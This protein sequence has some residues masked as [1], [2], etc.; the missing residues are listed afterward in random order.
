MFDLDEDD[1]ISLNDLIDFYRLIYIDNYK[2]KIQQNQLK[3]SNLL[4]NENIIQKMAKEMIQNFDVDG[5]KALNYE[6]FK[7]VLLE[8]LYFAKKITKIQ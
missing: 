5:D 4:I 7:K 1:I 2:E 8:F 6:E 3:D